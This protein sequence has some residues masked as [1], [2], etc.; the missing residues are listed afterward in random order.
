MQMAVDDR[1]DG[2]VR[3]NSHSPGVDHGELLFMASG[4]ETLG[5]YAAIRI[6]IP[7][8]VEVAAVSKKWGTL[9]ILN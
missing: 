6:S 8:R 9:K 3:T 1:N 7:I 2:I 5:F 4:P